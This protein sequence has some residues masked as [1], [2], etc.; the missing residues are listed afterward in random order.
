[1]VSNVVNSLHGAFYAGVFDGLLEGI[2]HSR[3]EGAIVTC[4][5]DAT[6][7]SPGTTHTWSF[8]K[9]R[10]DL[11]IAMYKAH[12]DELWKDC[13]IPKQVLLDYRDRLPPRRTMQTRKMD[14]HAVE[15]DPG[16]P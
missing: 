6:T 13:I 8:S 7:N 2:F 1:M 14:A 15:V 5:M 4:N 10:T 9:V 16:S 3:M 11:Q 12:V